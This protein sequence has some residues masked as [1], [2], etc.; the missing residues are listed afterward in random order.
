VAFGNREVLRRF[1]RDY[2]NPNQRAHM[3]KRTTSQVTRSTLPI[4]H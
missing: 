3:A 1:E 4:V 2:L